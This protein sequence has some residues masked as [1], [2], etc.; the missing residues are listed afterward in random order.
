MLEIRNTIYPHSG[1]PVLYHGAEIH[2]AQK[3]M[4]M[5]HGRGANAD[6][7]LG[8]IRHF[9]A[10]NIIYI[11]PQASNFTWYPY[12]FIEDREQNEPGISSGLTLINSI[13]DALVL[14]QIN[15]ENIYLLGF[16]QGACLVSDYAA[17]NPNRY[18]AVFCLS[19]ALIGQKLSTAEFKGDLRQTPVFFG[20]SEDDFHIPEERIHESA[21][22]FESLNAFVTKRIYPPFGH[23]INIDEISFI[24]EIITLS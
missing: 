22:I 2:S 10:N 15:R 4:I 24:N 14:K 7:M 21:K 17:R 13:V 1:Q 11:I 16:S 12:R 19:G 9:K 23:T 5:I 20:C 18:A 8:L 6:S 3:A